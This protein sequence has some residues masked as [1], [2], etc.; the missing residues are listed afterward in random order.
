MFL[1]SQG[2]LIGIDNIGSIIKL[3]DVISPIIFKAVSSSINIIFK[4]MDFI[5]LYSL[6]V[7]E[8][9]FFKKPKSI[10]I[11]INKENKQY[12]QVK[13][14]EKI[15]SQYRYRF[16]LSYKKYEV[17]FSVTGDIQPIYKITY[18][19]LNLKSAYVLLCK[20]FYNSYKKCNKI[21]FVKVKYGSIF[22]F[23]EYWQI[24]H[25]IMGLLVSESK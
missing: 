5:F 20:L 12:I 2:F 24:F 1:L 9:V 21:A 16:K 10:S 6:L 17:N 4:C 15:L 3:L 11:T 8:A 13:T 19:F 18:L 22:Y 7:K 25:I 23:Y 14:I